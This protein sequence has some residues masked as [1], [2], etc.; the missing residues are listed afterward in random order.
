MIK[1]RKLISFLFNHPAGWYVLAILYLSAFDKWG[2]GHMDWLA[3][4]LAGSFIGTVCWSFYKARRA[5][6]KYR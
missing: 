4:F 6:M 2:W 5:E 1:V 3:G